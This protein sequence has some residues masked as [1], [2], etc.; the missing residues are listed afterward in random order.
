MEDL[1]LPLKVPLCECAPYSMYM[2]SHLEDLVR[3][4]SA[5]IPLEHTYEPKEAMHGEIIS[6]ENNSKRKL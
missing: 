3:I 4:L 5:L 6:M 1:L 2:L